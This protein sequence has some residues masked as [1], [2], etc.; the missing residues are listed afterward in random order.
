MMSVFDKSIIGEK[1]GKLTVTDEYKGKKNGTYWKCNCDCGRDSWVYRGKLTTGHTKS[2][3]CLN[4]SLNGLSSHPLHTVWSAIKQRCYNKKSTN[5]KHYGE[6][7]IELCSD[8]EDFLSFYDWSLKNGY[9]KGLSIDRIDNDKSYS[10]DNCQWITISENTAK[11]NRHNVRRKTKYTYYAV[12]P[13]GQKYEF[14][15][16]AEFS[17]KHKLNSNGVRRVARGERKTYKG[18][19]FGYTDKLNK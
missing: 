10:P 17:R 13:S 2:C 5:Y 9:K 8:W 7:G 6:R 12:S 4:K 1:F 18:W 3:G 15:N 11:A 14:A 19:K 16:A